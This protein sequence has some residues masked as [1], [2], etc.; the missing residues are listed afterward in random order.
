MTTD[1]LPVQPADSP[2]AFEGPL[3]DGPAVAFFHRMDWSAFWTV[4]ALVFAVY[5]VTLAPTVTLEDSGELAVAS[6]YLGVPHPPGYPVWTL[7]TWFFQWV[8]HWVKYYGQPDSSFGLLAKS[9]RELLGAEGL[10]GYPNPAWGV[11]LSSALFGALSCAILALLISRSGAALLRSVPR[12]NAAVGLRSENRICWAAAVSGGLLFGFSPAMW[13]QSVIVEV[14]A[15]NAFFE[16]L[17]VL[18]LYRWMCRPK[19]TRALYAVAFFFGLGLTN[20]QTLLFLGLA[21][22]VAVLVRDRSLFRDFAIVGL[23][24]ALLVVFNVKAAAFGRTGLLWSQGPA[25]PA[26]WVFTAL[27]V[28]LPVLGAFLLPNGRT[29]CV[30]FLLL[31]LGLCFYLY[32]PLASE[33]N[34][35]MNWGYPRTWEGFLHAIGRGQYERI[36]PSDVFTRKFVLQLGAYLF[37]LRRQFTLPVLLIGLLPFSAWRVTV[38]GRRASAFGAALALAAL[39]ALLVIPEA[40][41][42]RSGSAP[43]LLA[44][45]VAVYRGLMFAI[46]ALATVG[47]TLT[48]HTFV[49]GLLRERATRLSGALLLGAIGLALLYVD[50]MLLRTVLAGGAGAGAA[51]ALLA[52][53]LGPPLL[54]A[55]VHRL[56][57]GPRALAFEAGT[58]HQTWL[59]TT[60]AG[61]VALSVI[62]VMFLNHSLDI[63]T[64]FI[65]RVQFIA[66]HALYALW[67][68]YGLLLA[69]TFLHL[70]AGRR[71][72]VPAAGLVLALLLPGVLLLRNAYDTEQVRILGGAEQNG[73][74]FGWQFGN[75]QLRGAE[76][77][78]E[79]IAPEERAAYPNPAYP[80]AMAPGAI[81]FGGTDPGR[82]VPTYMIYSADVRPDVYL[83]T[84]NALADNT[85]MNVMR[86][87][88]GDRIWIPSQPDSNRAFQQYVDEV[89]AGR[90]AAG[91]DVA[92]EDGRVRCRACRA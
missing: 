53:V 50:V 14:Y 86:D 63:Q 69:L 60:L 6:D 89:Q 47:F 44:A 71:R 74:D 35:P 77:I 88:Y 16:L 13:S 54:A 41:L 11:G 3:P 73:H 82:F 85:Y 42:E 36:T 37:D 20:H 78:L 84:Q 80:P 57:R 4:F 45:I 83:I 67:L 39:A 25:A 48:V 90:S 52:L 59:V 70:L 30:A 55:A 9:L 19:E 79:E 1:A 92:I 22:A 17:V 65:G 12:F 7:V 24:L 51:L 46:A 26:F 72:A 32:L 31:G 38:A 49:A 23:G 15:L 87:L 75:Y 58:E 40:L 43:A 64:Q 5:F 76:A 8:F 10:H 28:L 68:G 18:L 33:Q 81:F 34:P 61:F 91:A 27:A 2:D 21:L 62:F 29:V 56:A 66:S